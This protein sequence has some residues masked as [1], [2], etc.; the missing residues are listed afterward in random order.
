[1]ANPGLS[2]WLRRIHMYAGLFLAPWMVMYALST[3]A[4]NHRA[5]FRRPGPPA[6][7]K[8]REL[9]YAGRFPAD[10]KP[11][12]MARA[13]LADLGFEGTHSVNAARDGSRITIQRQDPV[14]PR[15]IT[16]EPAAGRLVVEKEVFRMPAFLERMHRRRGYAPGG[17]FQNLW[18]FS[19]DAVIAA[20]LFWVLSGLWLWWEMK[21]TRLLGGALAAAGCALFALFLF[22]I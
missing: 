2:L 12:Q 4:M 7:E 11:A 19:V 17:V 13:I 15:R 16:F 10:A 18:A 8:E 9:A 14:T 22:R 3:V 6:L 20:M 5:L 1:M 21:R